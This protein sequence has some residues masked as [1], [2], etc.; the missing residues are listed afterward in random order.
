[1]S[2]TGSRT[3]EILLRT[4]EVQVHFPTGE[5]G[6]WLPFGGATSVV[7]AVDG[8]SLDVRQGEILGLVGESGC[9]KTT[10]GR[11]LVG[12]ERPTSGS[13]FFQGQ[14]LKS[15]TGS[16][17]KAF[18][19]RMQIIFQDP[20]SSL[21]PRMTIESAISRPLV[22]HRSLTPAERREMVASIL[23]E[24]GLEPRIG[25]RFP[26]EF[27]GGQRQRIAIARGLVLNPDFVV[28]D[29]PTSSLDVSIQ[30]QILALLMRLQEELGLTMLFITHD[31]GVIRVMC[32][33]VAVMY[34][35]RIVELAGT[36]ELFENP[37]H[38]YTQ[39]LLSAVPEPDPTRRRERIR[40]HG[41][42]PSAVNPPSGC[43]LYPRCPMAGDQC[44]QREPTLEDWG[45]DHW[46]ACFPAG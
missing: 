34:L 8:V 32:D 36:E 39:A 33:R 44:S 42:V 38:P 5:S 15:L 2:S 43:R 26:H 7:H 4:D 27:S 9:G 22:I 41:G 23:Q 19:S 18:C 16:E 35:G 37:V 31:L 20:F 40:L 10:F 13:I 24:V 12:L 1:M 30:A 3:A 28:A 11:A 21:N 14:D 46:V 25:E 6:G 29:E 45:N 17:R